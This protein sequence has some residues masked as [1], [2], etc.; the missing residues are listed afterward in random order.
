MLET[1]Q[2]DGRVAVVT[3]SGRGLG[4]AMAKALA[5]AGAEIVCAARTAEQIEATADEIREAGGTAITVPTDVSD[6]KQVD[7]LV[8]ACVAEYGKI[9]IMIANAGGGIPAGDVEFWETPD[10][11]L[12]QVLAVNLKS[13]FYSGR[14]ATK[15]M[16]AQGSGGVL[17]NVASGT[18]LR[19]NPN[20]AY[21]TAKGGVISLTKSEA[22]MLWR[23]GIRANVIVPGYVSQRPAASDEEAEIRKNRGLF[24]PVRRLGEWWE[25]GPLAVYLASDASKYVTG[26]EFIIDG[27]GLAGG[28]GPVNFAPEHELEG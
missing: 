25:L 27:G 6:S 12:E 20:F 5:Q 8:E 22:T 28:V 18:A 21:P 7:A 17:I 15:A 3:G 14:A 10:E 9:D 16:V 1:L 23:H 11:H 13:A 26:E 4:K 24:V 2:L 19:G